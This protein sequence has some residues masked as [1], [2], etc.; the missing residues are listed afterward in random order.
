[1]LLSLSALSVGKPAVIRRVSGEP[2]LRRRLLE[3]GLIPGTV[4]LVRKR[5]P[6]GDPLQLHLRGFELTIRGADAENI[7]VE[8]IS[9]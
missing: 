3:L 8:V 5:A 4:L 1:M 9:S 2:A 7:Q 6:F